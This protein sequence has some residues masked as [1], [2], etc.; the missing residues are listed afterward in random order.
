MKTIMLEGVHLK[1]ATLDYPPFSFID[2]DAKFTESNHLSYNSYPI[3]FDSPSIT[4]LHRQKEMWGEFIRD[5][6]T[7]T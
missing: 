6:I 1:I 7:K 5:P 4:F 2:F 3:N